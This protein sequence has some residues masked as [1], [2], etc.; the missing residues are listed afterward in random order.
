MPCYVELST[1]VPNV[2][3][4]GP[5]CIF[6]GDI[7]LSAENRVPLHRRN[8]STRWMATINSRWDES[9]HHSWR[10]DS[11]PA[12]ADCIKKPLR[13]ASVERA[14][15]S[16]MMDSFPC[17]DSRQK[18]LHNMNDSG[19]AIGG[20]PTLQSSSPRAAINFRSIGPPEMPVREV[21][22]ENGWDYHVEMPLKPETTK[23]C[24]H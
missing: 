16:G 1:F 5:H 11:D 8:Y 17:D 9:S 22:Y 12:A 2:T 3:G 15:H 10:N 13:R 7:L 18:H 6:N 24:T 14:L 19:G 21:S 4:E 20:F 23:T